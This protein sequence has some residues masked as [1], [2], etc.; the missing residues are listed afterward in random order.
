MFCA[1]DFCIDIIKIEYIV[2][3]MRSMKG[4][5]M[6][7]ILIIEDNKEIALQIKKYLVKNSYEV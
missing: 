7:K 1:E 3:I 2:I 6:R 4:F 5:L